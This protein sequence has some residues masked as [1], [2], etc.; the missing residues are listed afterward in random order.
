MTLNYQNEATITA[1]AKNIGIGIGKIADA[2]SSIA[3][4]AEIAV[5]AYSQSVNKQQDLSKQNY[6][7]VINVDTVSSG[8]NVRSVE[9]AINTL[10][11]LQRP[12]DV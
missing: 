11:N 5:T 12:Q 9:D 10:N 2:L 4:T 3:S 8:N 7:I 6:T 1:A